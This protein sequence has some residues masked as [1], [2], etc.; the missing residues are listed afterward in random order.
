MARKKQA[1]PS[2]SQA[3]QRAALFAGVKE[4]SDDDAP[5]LV[6]ADW[7]EE[8]GDEDDRAHAELIR[9]QCEIL[10]RSAQII[11]PQRPE[12][13]HALLRAAGYHTCV[14]PYHF[15][16]LTDP[17]E[18]IVELRQ[19]EDEL[20]ERWEKSGR[21]VA[22]ASKPYCDWYRGF[23]TL[24]LKRDRFASRALATFAASPAGPWV[25]QL[26]IQLS[27]S[28]AD[29]IARNEV[30]AHAVGLEIDGMKAG[31]PELKTLLASPHLAGLRRI[32]PGLG[33]RA[34]EVAV[35]IRAPQCPRYT[36]LYLNSSG[37]DA[38]SIH[39]LVDADL[40]A[41]RW[42]AL[43]GSRLHA[44]GAQ[45]LGKAPF[46]G[47]LHALEVSNCGIGPSGMEGLVSGGHFRCPYSL[48]LGTNKIG[49]AGLRALL[50][51]PGLEDLSVI[52]LD[53]NDLDDAAIIDLAASPRV[54]GLLFM[55]LRRNDKIGPAAIEALASSPHLS[56]LASLNIYGCPVGEAGARALLN[57]PHLRKLQLSIAPT[58][59]SPD[60]MAALGERH[61]LEK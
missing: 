25:D 3:D 26:K 23:V 30:L 41:L 33:C 47:H 6:L 22:L 2:S 28:V 43:S 36:H 31:V 12:P 59:I 9:V 5:R 27:P 18:R 20:V 39:T 44:S 53:E 50:A 19:R 56:R 4:T 42:L 49:T 54:T 17:D 45:A 1:P 15:S 35:V 58:D 34:T 38:T 16:K 60:T 10:A 37:L 7:L 52:E 40:P 55:D 24:N 57:S 46:L 8:N 32:T 61:L 21:L 48:E 29:Q 11:N 51:A 13:I 14:I